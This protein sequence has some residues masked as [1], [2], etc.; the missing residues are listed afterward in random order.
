MPLLGAPP[1][2]RRPCP[3][4]SALHNAPLTKPPSCT[5]AAATKS[6]P[7]AMLLLAP[8]IAIH[9]LPVQPCHSPRVELKQADAPVVGLLICEHVARMNGP[10]AWPRSAG[11][12]SSSVSIPI[13]SSAANPQ[14]LIS[15][16]SPSREPAPLRARTSAPDAAAR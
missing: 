5:P 10:P 7:F 13:T 12:R 11:G 8:E 4:T 16:S 14:R 15:A 1:C 2:R 3:L 9:A 6:T